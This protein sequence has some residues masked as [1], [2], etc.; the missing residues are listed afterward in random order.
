ME[1]AVELSTDVVDQCY[2]RYKSTNKESCP[3]P[4]KVRLTGAI[5]QKSRRPSSS[6]C[7][8]RNQDGLFGLRGPLIDPYLEIGR[9]A[10]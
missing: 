2:D 7:Q 5:R 8:V 9:T 10:Q 3:A 1:F 6:S 4:F